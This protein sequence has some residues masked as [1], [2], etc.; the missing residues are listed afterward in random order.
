MYSEFD[1]HC[2]ILP[3]DRRNGYEN[4]WPVEIQS[5]P[6]MQEHKLWASEKW[7]NDFDPAS[8]VRL[9]KCQQRVGHH[10]FSDQTLLAAYHPNPSLG[11]S[12]D[13]FIWHYHQPAAVEQ[14]P[15]WQQTLGSWE[16][17]QHPA[18]N[19]GQRTLGWTLRARL[20]KERADRQFLPVE[21]V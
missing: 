17:W 3:I 8:D 4:G 12:W 10:P 15:E 11:G 20:A 13:P 18:L 2:K 5:I 19:P 9:L 6:K 14:E 7:F 16:H 1:L 21:A